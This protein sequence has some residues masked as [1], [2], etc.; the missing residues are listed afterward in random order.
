MNDA[1]SPI[2][3][4]TVVCD[5]CG[6]RVNGFKVGD[7][8]TSGFYD[9]SKSA[10]IRF[11]KSPDEKTVCESCMWLDPVWRKEYSFVESD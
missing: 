10:W 3:S 5:R 7:F 6:E 8:G 11:A 9:V 2:V 4:V 1:P